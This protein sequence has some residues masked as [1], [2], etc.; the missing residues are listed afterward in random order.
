MQLGGHT[1]SLLTVQSKGFPS[2]IIKK[3]VFIVALAYSNGQVYSLLIVLVSPV[4]S[5][6]FGF[7]VA[8]TSL[9]YVGLLVSSLVS[10]II[11]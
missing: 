9:Y 7:R 11:L 2:L 3:A 5:D 4:L 8:D 1:H 10:V 6:Q